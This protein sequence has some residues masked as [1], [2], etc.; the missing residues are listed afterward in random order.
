MTFV[1]PEAVRL[2]A[3]LAGYAT[4]EEAR[5]LNARERAALWADLSEKEREAGREAE[6]KNREEYL[7]RVGGSAA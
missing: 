7:A 6:R 3:V 1:S 4:K 2:A 5:R